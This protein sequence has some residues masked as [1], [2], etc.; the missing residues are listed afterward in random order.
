MVVGVQKENALQSTYCATSGKEDK[1]H[2]IDCLMGG[3]VVMVSEYGYNELYRGD[4]RQILT[5]RILTI[6][7]FKV[8]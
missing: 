2:R 8:E 7:I 1:I 5:Y 4:K 3:W 6:C